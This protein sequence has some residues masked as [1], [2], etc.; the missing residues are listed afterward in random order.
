MEDDSCREDVAVGFNVSILLEGDDLWGDVPGGA[1]TVEEIA[2]QVG[3][4]GQAVVDDDRLE[5]EIVAQHY[6]LRL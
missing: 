3:V 6:V 5:R 1:A 2:G 4:G